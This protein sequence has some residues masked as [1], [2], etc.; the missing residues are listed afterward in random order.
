MHEQDLIRS[1]HTPV[2]DHPHFTDGEA[3]A[4][5]GEGAWITVWVLD[6]RGKAG[7][8]YPSPTT[9]PGTPTTGCSDVRGSQASW[10]DPLPTASVH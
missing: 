3:Q 4:Q 2:R 7:P 1:S 5:T 9:R 8:I 6:A 10:D